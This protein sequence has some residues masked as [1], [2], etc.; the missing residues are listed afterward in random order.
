MKRLLLLF[1]ISLVCATTTEAES[2]PGHRPLKVTVD[3]P[4]DVGLRES[5]WDEYCVYTARPS[6]GTQPYKYQWTFS[7]GGSGGTSQTQR[8]GGSRLGNQWIQVKVTD[9]NGKTAEKRLDVVVHERVEVSNAETTQ[10]P[11][12]TWYQLDSHR[13]LSTTTP[14]EHTFRISRSTRVTVGL[15]VTGELDVEKI[16]AKIGA[17]RTTTVEVETTIEKTIT[18]TIPPQRTVKIMGRRM[19]NLTKGD[20][21][22][23]GPCSKEAEGTYENRDDPFIETSNEEF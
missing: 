2:P 22:Q 6:G 20:A 21:I 18:V 1:L 14:V 17:S 3:G 4:T 15:T 23:W 9:K 12:G 19:T 10:E 16:G 11:Q 5:F 13:N 7:A 8:S